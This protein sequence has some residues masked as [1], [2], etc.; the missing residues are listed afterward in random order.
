MSLRGLYHRMKQ[1]KMM[2]RYAEYIRLNPDSYYGPGFIIDMRSPE[3]GKVYLETGAHC[4]MEG[5]IGRAS[6]RERVLS[7]V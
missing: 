1:K 4:V 5:K 6:C 7:N 3:K 2:R